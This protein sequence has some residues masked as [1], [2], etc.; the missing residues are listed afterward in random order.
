MSYAHDGEVYNKQNRIIMC[1]NKESTSVKD[2]IELPLL[3]RSLYENALRK[4]GIS[5]NKIRELFA[6][7]HGNLRALIRRIPGNII[8]TRPE[9]AKEENIDALAPLVLMRSVDRKKG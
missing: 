7:T 1:F 6:F 5:D 8:V 4:M 2:A 9:W 3:T